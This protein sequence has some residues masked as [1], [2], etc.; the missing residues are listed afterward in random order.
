MA[1][2]FW[3]SAI[4][5]R[6]TR[7]SSTRPT[8]S[9]FISFTPFPD[10]LGGVPPAQ[11]ASLTAANFVIEG[12]VRIRNLRVQSVE[13][14]GAVMTLRVNTSGDF[15]ILH[16]PSRPIAGTDPFE[17]PPPGFDP[18][19]SQIEFSFKVAC[20]TDFDCTTA[21]TAVPPALTEPATNY[22]SKDYAT[23]RR[24]MLDRLSVVMPDWRERTPA[25]MQIALVELMAYVGDFLSYYQDAVATEAYL[26]T[27]RKRVSVR[28]HA[29]L[30]DY[31]MHEGS[32]AR[33]WVCLEVETNSDA[34]GATLPAGTKLLT[35]G[36]HAASVVDLAGTTTAFDPEAPEVFETMDDVTLH[37]ERNVIRFHTWSERDCCLPKGATKATL[38][39]PPVLVNMGAIL[40]FE[41]ILSPTTGLGRDAD[42]ARRCAVRVSQRPRPFIDPLTDA[43][44]I[45]IEWSDEDALPFPLC[46]SAVVTGSDGQQTLFEPTVARGNVV[47]VDHGA[48]IRD[49]PLVPP[50]V[51]AIGSYRPTLA[52]KDLTF[53]GLVSKASATAAM[54]YDVHDARPV[55]SLT[56]D[57]GSWSPESDLL[58]SEAFSRSFVVEIQSDREAHLRFG[59]GISGRKPAA[60]A[61]FTASYRRGSGTRGNVGAEAIARIEF[62]GDGITRVRNPIAATGGRDPE[63][64][65]QVR[66]FAP[67]AFRSQERAVTEA[68]YAAI[69]ERNTDVQ[70]A[71]ATFRWTGSWYTAFVT[72]DRKAGRP[73]GAN[74]TTTISGLP[75]ALSD[76]GIRRGG[77]QPRVRAARPH[78]VGLCEAGLFPERREAIVATGV[79]QSRPP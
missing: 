23:F 1:S 16:A 49:E 65:E 39:G 79:Q 51:P 37:A 52:H 19:L 57:G 70:H 25:D 9:R 4:R 48:T 30:L 8:R 58:S 21:T 72:V 27:A 17:Q 67:R 18:A 26:G 10:R 24:L 73:V 14:D 46:V 13:T 43:P 59:D 11:A 62:A 29:R 6:R 33:A 53:Q 68:D 54:E 35:G 34:D 64:L 31:A 40:V 41:E 20:P 78:A 69:A 32:N 2:I 75:G 36:G 28:R 60:G 45:E 74:F 56:G 66:Q 55:I 61:T 22:L 38:L 76:G 63:A 12:G 77:Q 42:A 3:R 47:L 15:S 71:A 5:L 50:D 7:R 44:V